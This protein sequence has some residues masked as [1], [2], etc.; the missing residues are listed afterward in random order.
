MLWETEERHGAQNCRV[1]NKPGEDG[2]TYRKKNL[3][4]ERSYSKF[5]LARCKL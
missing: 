4:Y 3:A 5:H 1:G 2:F